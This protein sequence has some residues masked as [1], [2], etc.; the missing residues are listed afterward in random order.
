MKSL[1]AIR[2]VHFEDLGILESLLLQRGFSIRYLE[3]GVDDL[4]QINTLNPDLLVVL[5]GP[6]GAYEANIYPFL[7]DELAVVKHRLQQKNPILGICLGAQLM[8]YSLGAS[9]Q[10]MGV[11]EIG[12]APLTFD[13]DNKTG[14]LSALTVPVLHWHGDFFEVPDGGKL[15]A[16]SAICQQQAFSLGTYALGLQFHLEANPQRIEQWL[17]GHASELASAKINIQQIR[18]DAA[19]YG[20][21]LKKQGQQVIGT[22]LTQAGL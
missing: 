17:I 1:I 12:F 8:A 14:I 3:A 22:W 7:N 5:G 10:Y 6:I 4:L 19:Q 2:H 16:S 18:D 9:V 15:L 11:K 20:D 21:V 13:Q